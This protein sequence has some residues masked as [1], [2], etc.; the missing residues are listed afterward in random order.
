MASPITRKSRVLIVDDFAVVRMMLRRYLTDIGIREIDEAKDGAEAMHKIK[1]AQQVGR[2]YGIVFIDW[3]MPKKTGLDVL[4]ECRRTDAFKKIPII[5]V[6]AEG[7]RR[8]VMK[9]IQ[10]G[11]TDYIVKPFTIEVLR[12][13]IKSL[14]DRLLKAK[15]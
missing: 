10:I 13:K 8:Q 3:T 11:A 7:E 12:A 5:L 1:E 9:A 15:T 4:H 2:G 6:T 14:N